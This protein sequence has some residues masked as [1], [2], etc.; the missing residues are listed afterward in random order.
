MKLWK[1][2]L[3]YT[4]NVKND[5]YYI[6][7]A[8]NDIN[9]IQK[10]ISNNSYDE[11]I[12]DEELVDAVMF[13]LIQLVENIKHLSGDVIQNNPHIE[14]GNLIGFR[15]G[16]VHEYG[17]TDYNIVYET[18]TCDLEPLKEALEKYIK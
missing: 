14:W 18:I 4:D 7:K 8:I 17:A 11:F 15:N 5:A 6:A 10:Y 12:N 2:E 13:R 3:R 16:I 9:S 1:E